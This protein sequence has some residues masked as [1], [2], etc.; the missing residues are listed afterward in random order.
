MEY[1]LDF[2][3]NSPLTGLP[4]EIVKRVPRHGYLVVRLLRGRRGPD[5]WRKGDDVHALPRQVV[6][7]K[8]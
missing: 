5:G 4:V 8:P 7:V 2:G 1:Q 3:T 6:E